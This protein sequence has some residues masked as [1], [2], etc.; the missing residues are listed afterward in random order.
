MRKYNIYYLT[1]ISKT[2]SPS[3]RE[4]VATFMEGVTINNGILTGENSRIGPRDGVSVI[5]IPEDYL[6]ERIQTNVF[7][8]EF[9]DHYMETLRHATQFD[10]PPLSDHKARVMLARASTRGDVIQSHPVI[11]ER[12]NK[13]AHEFMCVLNLLPSHMLKHLDIGA[14]F[15][16]LTHGPE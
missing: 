8:I 12:A 6:G 5:Y 2:A 11:L 13:L 15:V 14:T 16:V 3:A 10:V 4:H 1:D 9:F 7:L